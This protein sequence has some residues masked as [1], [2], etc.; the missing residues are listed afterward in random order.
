MVQAGFAEVVA[1]LVVVLLQ[2]IDQSWKVDVRVIVHMAEPSE[3]VSQNN[4]KV[5]PRW[6]VWGSHGCRL[7]GRLPRHDVIN[8]IL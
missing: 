1:F 3:T 5:V 8:D 6:I 2:K 4:N 7:A